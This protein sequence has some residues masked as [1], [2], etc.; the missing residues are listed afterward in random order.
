MDYIK[1]SHS[2][3]VGLQLFLFNLSYLGLLILLFSQITFIENLK[4]IIII[5][6]VISFILA[7]H[8]KK[9]NAELNIPNS[10]TNARLTI[11]IFILSIVFNIEDYNEYLFI[12]LILISLLLDGADGF[13]SRYLMQDTT[14]GS[15]FDQEVDNFLILI[16][17]ISLV[18][19]YDF[20]FLILIIPMYRYIFILL[21]RLN[22]ISNQ[23]LPPSFFRKLICVMTILSL[24]LCNIYSTVDSI[25]ILLYLVFILISY[26]FVKDAFYLHRRKYD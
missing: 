18:Y 22:V 13:L 25:R 11:N 12:N 21:I 15:L 5:F 7:F 24:A 6:L 20:I 16:L 26:S 17:T 3:Y 1:N 9:H 8:F 19:N 14:F 4:K 2:S 10:L 23:S